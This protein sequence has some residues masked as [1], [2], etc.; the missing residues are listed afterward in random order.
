M[1]SLWWDALDRQVGRRIGGERLRIVRVVTLP[2]EDR[3]D[4]VLPYSL[5]GGQDAQLV[6]HQ[7]IVVSGI[8]ALDVVELALLVDVDQDVSVHDL[9]KSRALDLAWLKH[10]VAIGEDDRR[11]PSAEPFQNVERVRV[12]AIRERV[13]HQER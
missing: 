6:V 1:P 2:R 3:G 5:H 8:P 7:D 9:L 10:R 4:S 12:E 13:I 11:S